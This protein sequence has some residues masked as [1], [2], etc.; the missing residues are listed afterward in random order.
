M[1]SCP[2]NCPG[3]Y[4]GGFWIHSRD[5]QWA[6]VLWKHHGFTVKDWACP[7]DCDPIEMSAAWTHPYDCVFW[8]RTGYTP[9]DQ[10]KAKP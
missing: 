3:E 5:C 8:D 4:V 1:E 9:F 6:S 2:E 7:F 10:L